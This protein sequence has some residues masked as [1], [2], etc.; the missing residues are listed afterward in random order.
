MA[1]SRGC[2]NGRNRSKRRGNRLQFRFRENRDPRIP[3][4]GPGN[5]FPRILRGS[6][7]RKAKGGPPNPGCVPSRHPSTCARFGRSRQKASQ[8]HRCR[9]RRWSEPDGAPARKLRSFGRQ[10]QNCSRRESIRKLD[11]I[12]RWSKNRQIIDDAWSQSLLEAND[13]FTRIH[14]FEYMEGYETLEII[15]QRQAT[16]LAPA[17]SISGSRSR[18]SLL[19]PI[20]SLVE[21]PVLRSCGA[22]KLA[23]EL[24]LL[25]YHDSGHGR[26]DPAEVLCFSMANAV[27][28]TVLLLRETMLPQSSWIGF[29]HQTQPVGMFG[30]GVRFADETELR[31]AGLAIVWK[32]KRR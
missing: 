10:P 29:R 21:A 14:P 27:A 2:H 32:R 18:R 7:A 24:S 1:R 3:C 17:T 6:A 19:L 23:W 16:T 5:R 8:Q 22:L 20:C 4:S 12:C 15:R 30:S 25:E 9:L 28:E 13:R 11:E 26:Q 31:V